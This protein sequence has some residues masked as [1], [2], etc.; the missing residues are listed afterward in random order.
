MIVGRSSLPSTSSGT[1]G[2]TALTKMNRPGPTRGGVTESSTTTSASPMPPWYWSGVRTSRDTCGSVRRTFSRNR[3]PALTSRTAIFLG[4]GRT[5]YA[6]LSTA[7]SS[8]IRSRAVGED[9]DLG[10][11]LRRDERAR[12]AHR[13]L[14]PGGEV[15]GLGGPDGR[16]RPLTVAGQRRSLLR[17]HPGL[18]DH[19]FGALT[20]A[21]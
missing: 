3:L 1:S 11:G 5:A 17:L 2:G 9:V 7:R 16:Q 18:D 21:A 12:R 8:S 20:E 15:A 4:G 13:L 6:V 14:D 19:D 10:P